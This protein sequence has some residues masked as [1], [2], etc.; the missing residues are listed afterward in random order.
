M[1]ILYKQPNNQSN[2]SLQ[3]MD[4]FTIDKCYLKK[5]SFKD[6]SKLITKKSHHHTG[7][8]IHMINEGSQT[9]EIE[10]DKLEVLAG[11]LILIPPYIQHRSINS[12]NMILKHSL[13]FEFS[14]ID[15]TNSNVILSKIPKRITDNIKH[16]N[17]EKEYNKK[18]SSVLIENIVFEIIVLILR[19]A[20]YVETENISVS[21]TTDSRITLA[22]QYIIDNIKEPLKLS[23][24]SNYCHI[25]TK[26]LTRIFSESENITPSKYIQKQ[27]A[28]YIEN[29]LKNTEFHLKDISEM[30]NFQ[31][32][33]YFN[34]FF[35][36][37]FGMP[38][39]EYRKI[40]K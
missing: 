5:I 23:E 34:T 26:Q 22:K 31:N 11:N 12:S 17:F 4:S 32:E 28:L 40:I 14:P 27:R 25:S 1:Q 36:K 19:I 39:G 13:T 18:T 10:G 37:H 8:E 16:I 9:Y 29:L 3:F 2:I 30:M 20:G 38:P 21:S 6:N 33:Y 7:F 15:H 24:I 35:K